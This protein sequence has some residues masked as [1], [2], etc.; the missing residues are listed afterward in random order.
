MNAIDEHFL[1]LISFQRSIS[2]EYSKSLF[3]LAF[4][5]FT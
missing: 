3:Q 1:I 5:N 4:L 2:E